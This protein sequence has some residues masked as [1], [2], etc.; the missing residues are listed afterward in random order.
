MPIPRII[1]YCW[2]GG[3]EK[4]E[5]IRKCI[6]SWKKYCP[7]YEIKEWNESN[8]DINMFQYTKEAYNAKKW[9][10]V[11]DVARLWVVLNYGGIYMD[12]DVEVFDNIDSLLNNDLFMF[13][14]SEI[15]INSGMGFGATK[16]NEIIQELVNDY[17]DRPFLLSN[18][19]YDL[20]GCPAINT[21]TIRKLIP[22]LELGGRTQYFDNSIAFFSPR[23]YHKLMR[24]YGVASWINNP[25]L[26]S[27]QKELKDTKLKRFLRKP[28][29]VSLIE[30]HLS[31]KLFDF[32]I[33]ISYDLLDYGLMYFIKSLFKK[34]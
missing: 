14:E 33:F 21:K 26:D 16:D 30:K 24:H 5:I 11:S 23:D 29:R 32:Y 25:K 4:P 15:N 17:S 12:T 28:S 8:F 10:F 7:D 19:K 3:N 18:G 6:F 2:F 22:S 13:F 34:I 1:H 31:K 9:A 20:T 27:S